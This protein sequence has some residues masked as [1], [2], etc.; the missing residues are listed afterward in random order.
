MEEASSETVD[1]VADGGMINSE[2]EEPEGGGDGEGPEIAAAAAAAVAGG[3]VGH[4]S[5]QVEE[6]E[7]EAL[8]AR[9]EGAG[10]SDVARPDGVERLQMQRIRELDLEQLE[11][12]EVDS[13]GGDVHSD[14]SRSDNHFDILTLFFS[15]LLSV[16]FACGEYDFLAA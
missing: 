7:P 15:F 5:P 14:D 1:E 3:R 8:V 16:G 13:D 2:G 6:R 11:V 10:P 12:E 4:F 9:G